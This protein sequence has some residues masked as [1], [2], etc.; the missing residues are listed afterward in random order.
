MAGLGRRSNG[1]R[2]K[3]T[4][5]WVLSGSLISSV[6]SSVPP[7][8]LKLWFPHVKGVRIVWVTK[9]W[10]LGSICELLT[11]S[12]GLANRVSNKRSTAGRGRETHWKKVQSL[13]NTSTPELDCL[14]WE[15]AH[16][17]ESTLCF[18]PGTEFQPITNKRPGDLATRSIVNLFLLLYGISWK[19]RKRSLAQFNVMNDIYNNGYPVWR[20]IRFNP[21]PETYIKTNCPQSEDLNV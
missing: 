11:H 7:S 13:G 8:F 14:E 19:G 4:W 1:F 3:W 15:N 20:K 2:I 21:Y 18:K 17:L 6:T 16:G 10:G 9:S 12:R 5:T